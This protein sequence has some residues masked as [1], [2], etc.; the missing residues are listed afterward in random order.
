MTEHLIVEREAGLMTLRLNRLDKKNALTRAMYS[1][2]PRL[3]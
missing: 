1:S 3:C 2:W